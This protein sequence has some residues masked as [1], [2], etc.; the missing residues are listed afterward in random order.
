MAKVR[1]A[2][3]QRLPKLVRKASAVVEALQRQAEAMQKIK[4]RREALVTRRR[5]L[6]GYAPT[7]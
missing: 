5:I 6:A 1:K 4:D 2:S 3:K 7:P